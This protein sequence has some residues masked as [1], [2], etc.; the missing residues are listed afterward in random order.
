MD[1][2]QRIDKIAERL[3][4]GR[5]IPLNFFRSWMVK[6]MHLWEDLDYQ[7]WLLILDKIKNESLN[8]YAFF[9]FVY[10]I[11]GIEILPEFALL[12]NVDEAVRKYVDQGKEFPLHTLSASDLVFYKK[13]A[14]A[15]NKAFDIRSKLI[16]Q[17]AKANENFTL[18]LGEQ[19]GNWKKYRIYRRKVK[20]ADFARISIEDS[21]QEQYLFAERPLK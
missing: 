14:V 15:I 18:S 10:R 2:K 7:D 5:E 1:K 9:S 3:M 12:K 16:L 11:L 17:G 19:I 21:K 8:L 4:Q 13:N 20:R 6:E